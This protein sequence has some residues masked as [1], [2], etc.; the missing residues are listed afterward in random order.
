MVERDMSQSQMDG[1]IFGIPMGIAGFL[2][3]CVLIMHL[4]AP[5]SQK[6]LSENTPPIA[7]AALPIVTTEAPQSN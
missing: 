4:L 3:L 6:E 5:K 2:M 7:A 1:L